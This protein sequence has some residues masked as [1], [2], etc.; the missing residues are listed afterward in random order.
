MVTVFYSSSFCCAGHSFDTTRKARWVA[1][2]LREHPI[3]EVELREPQPLTAQEVAEVHDAAYVRAIETGQPRDL[4]ASQGF[5]WDPGLWPMVL[6]SNGGAVAAA[7]MA[8]REGVSGSLSSGLHHARHECGAGF[9]T[10][11]GLVLAAKAVLAE[12]ARSVL[13]LD[14]DAHC[15]G[16]TH[17]LVEDDSRIWQMDVSVSSVDRYEPCDRATLDVVEVASEYLPTVTSR[18][19]EWGGQGPR[20]DLCLYNA[21]MDPYQGCP[22]GGF[23]GSTRSPWRI[24]SKSSSSGARRARSRWPSCSRA[25]T[26]GRGWIG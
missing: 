19:Q 17:S 25:V 4:A 6:S 12:G 1:D 23:P 2:S 3:P 9:C 11:N 20:F 15:G 8:R 18:L 7:R 10:F 16:G 14:L 26:S 5:N 13:I 22:I 21:G 24:V